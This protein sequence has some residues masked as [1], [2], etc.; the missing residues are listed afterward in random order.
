MGRRVQNVKVPHS[1]GSK[2]PGSY[3]SALSFFK[4]TLLALQLARTDFRMEGGGKAREHTGGIL[5]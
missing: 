1:F 2:D 5:S 3:L 4:V